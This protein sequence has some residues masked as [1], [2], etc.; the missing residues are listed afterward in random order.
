MFS[1]EE[2]EVVSCQGR[3]GKDFSKGSQSMVGLDDGKQ[4]RLLDAVHLI[5]EKENRDFGLSN[6]L[7]KVR[8][9]FAGG[10][11]KN[12]PTNEVGAF[13]RLMDLAQHPFPEPV[14]G[15][16][17]AGRIEKNRLA[18][19]LGEDSSNHSTGSLGL[20]GDGRETLSHQS[21]EEGG[22]S[23]VRLADDGN[24]SRTEGAGHG[25]GR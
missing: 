18:V 15:F 9:F 19:A 24:K 6:F 1:K 4:S 17:K 25:L 23:N 14:V 5:D 21:I 2:G 20:S 11:G 3:N 10:F 7:G 8:V 16:V 22:F 13:Q 12:H